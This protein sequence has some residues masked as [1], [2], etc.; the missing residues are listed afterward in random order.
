MP[1]N[2]PFYMPRE[3]CSYMFSQNFVSSI[4]AAYKRNIKRSAYGQKIQEVEHASF[5][6]VV[7]STSGSMAQEATIFYK[8]LALLLATKWNEEYCKVMG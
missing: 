6:P 7:S 1:L 3:N 4:S 2:L 8:R 5:T